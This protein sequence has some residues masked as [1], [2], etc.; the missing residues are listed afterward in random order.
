M[1]FE[2]CAVNLPSALAAMQA[3][4]QRIE[5]CSALDV[6]GLT[7]SPG[8]IRAAINHLNIRVNVLIRPREGDF[9]YSP[10]ELEVM[11]DDI[12]FCLE[13]GANGVVVGALTTGNRLD[14]PMMQAMKAAAGAM[15]IVCHRA[16]D[17]TEDP[18]QSI[19]ELVGL[20]YHR[21]LSSGQAPT[22]F[23][24]RLLLKRLIEHADGRISIMPGAGIN[25]TNIRD[26]ALVTAAQEFHFTGKKKAVQPGADI[27]GLERWYW[28]SD[29]ELIREIMA[30]V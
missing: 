11:L 14:L 6:G 19:D 25:K 18:F 24:G 8:L 16:F 26:I 27:P 17:F 29:A 10:G 30:A 5:L 9:C 13:A 20:G 23:E 15:E 21:I 3:G 7:P 28:E 1:T 2:I 22:A 12:R 4:A